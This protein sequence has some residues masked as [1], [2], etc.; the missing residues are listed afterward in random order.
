[1]GFPAGLART[2]VTDLTGKLPPGTRR[3][4]IVNNLKIYWD[5]IR[6]DQTPDPKD[7]RV[8]E[9]PLAS[10]ALEFL[11]YPRENSTLAGQRYNVLVCT[12]Q[13]DRSICAR[14]RELY[15]LRRCPRFAGAVG[16]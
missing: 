8:A 16:R 11:G 7:V 3:I 12:A 5:A 10:A 1:M 13:P 14:G 15:S 2:M 9:I 6:I 4:R